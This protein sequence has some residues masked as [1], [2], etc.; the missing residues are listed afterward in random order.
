MIGQL[1]AV[2]RRLAQPFHG[3]AGLA[4]CPSLGLDSSQSLPE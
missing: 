3:R 2:G 4:G 1:G